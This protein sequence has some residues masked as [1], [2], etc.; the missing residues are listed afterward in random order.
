MNRRFGELTWDPKRRAV[1][2]PVTESTVTIQ[3]D[4]TGLEGPER[5]YTLTCDLSRAT[6]KC[7]ATANEAR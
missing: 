7:T 2:V 1:V 4:N 3:R 5:K 6:R